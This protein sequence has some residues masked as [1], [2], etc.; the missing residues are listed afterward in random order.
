MSEALE[1]A[2]SAHHGHVPE[3]E[4]LSDTEARGIWPMEDVVL[5]R[6]FAFRGYGH[7]RETY[8]KVAGEWRIKTSQI[9]RLRIVVEQT[10]D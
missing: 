6:G 5:N 3:I 7:Y 2:Q 4:I 9:T 10:A 1:V 8:E